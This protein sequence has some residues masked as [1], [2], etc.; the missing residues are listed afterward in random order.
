MHF[1]NALRN[2]DKK[3]YLSLT[4]ILKWNVAKSLCVLKDCLHGNLNVFFVIFASLNLWFV[5]K[6]MQIY[7]KVI[8][9][10]D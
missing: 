2:W 8:T 7:S 5:I 9:D 6:N 4:T 10:E 1:I 3:I